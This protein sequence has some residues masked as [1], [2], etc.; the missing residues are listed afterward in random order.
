L[1]ETNL[2]VDEAGPDA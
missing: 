2:N 1:F